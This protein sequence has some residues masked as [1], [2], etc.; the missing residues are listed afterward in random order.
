MVNKAT[1]QQNVQAETE[2]T[3]YDLESLSVLRGI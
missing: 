3:I 2:Y 1:C